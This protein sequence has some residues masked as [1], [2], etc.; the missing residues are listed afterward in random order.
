MDYLDLIINEYKKR[1]EQERE[2][3]RPYLELPIPTYLD[4]PVEAEEIEEPKRVIIIE[5]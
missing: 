1:Q 5:L 2:D 4:K 3:N